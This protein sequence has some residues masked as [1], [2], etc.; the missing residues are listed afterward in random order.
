MSKIHELTGPEK[1]AILLLSLEQDQ[2]A[3]VL[4]QLRDDEV[5]EVV[6]EI[7]ALHVV[8]QETVSEIVEVF[9]ETRKQDVRLCRGGLDQARQILS[10]A[11]PEDRVDEIFALV[12]KGVIEPPFAWLAPVPP[13]DLARA[14]DYL[15]DSPFINGEI[16][17]VDGGERLK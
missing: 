3:S 2:A 8:E 1:A 7:A 10:A 16:L 14:L 12:D 13:A 11:V 17:F 4:R 6:T 5:S 9:A 15:I